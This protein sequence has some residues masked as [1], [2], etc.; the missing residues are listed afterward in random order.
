MGDISTNRLNKLSKSIAI[1]ALVYLVSP[2]DAI[3][4][5]IPFAGLLD[6]VGVIAAAVAKLAQELSKYRK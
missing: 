2:I 1:G 5:A 3:P 6:D 4:D